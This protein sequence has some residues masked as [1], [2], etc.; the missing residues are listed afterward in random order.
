MNKYKPIHIVSSKFL[1]N[2]W[3]I[4]IIKLNDSRYIKIIKLNDSWYIK[5]IDFRHFDNSDA[6]KQYQEYRLKIA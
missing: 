6:M 1:N 3:Y 4:K 5:I 2:S